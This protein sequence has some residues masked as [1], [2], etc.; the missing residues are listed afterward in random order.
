MSSGE[1]FTAEMR[2]SAARAPAARRRRRFLARVG[3]R[4]ARSS[5]GEHVAVLGEE[6]MQPVLPGS[7]EVGLLAMT[8][9]MPVGYWKDAA[10]T[11]A[12]FRVVDGTRYA[13]RGDYATVDADGTVRLVGRGNTAISTH[14][15]QVPAELVERS[16]GQARERR[17]LRGRRRSRRPFRG[18]DRRARGRRGEPL[19]R[20]GRAHRVVPHEARQARGAVSDSCSSTPCTATASGKVNHLRAPRARDRDPRARS[21]RLNAQAPR[22]SGARHCTRSAEGPSAVRAD[23][24]MRSRP[25]ALRF[26]QRAVGGGDESL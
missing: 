8:G 20:R 22:A 10:R 5:V 19:S 3:R 11:S 13:I 6:T 15:A 26:V 12:T 18:E 4:R 1:P 14:G 25:A 17:G 9:L 23:V 7:G 2:A 16:A 21:A 24:W